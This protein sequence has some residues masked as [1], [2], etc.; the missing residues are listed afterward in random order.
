MSEAIRYHGERVFHVSINEVGTLTV[1]LLSSFSNALTVSVP[2]FTDGTEV[3]FPKSRTT[4]IWLQFLNISV[5][6]LYGI[7]DIWPSD[8]V[9]V[10]AR[11]EQ[12][13]NIPL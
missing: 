5:N 2:P 3:K 8:I 12:P 7:V 9:A 10:P 13:L 11:F 6:A 4:F 1:N